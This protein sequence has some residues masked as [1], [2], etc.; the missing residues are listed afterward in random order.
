MSTTALISDAEMQV[1]A[2]VAETCAAAEVARLKAEIAKIEQEEAVRAEREKKEQELRL[3]ELE[4]EAAALREKLAAMNGIAAMGEPVDST[5]LSSDVANWLK[6]A[7]G[8]YGAKRKWCI[9]KAKEA[10]ESVSMPAP[11]PA[12]VA[13]TKPP[14]FSPP[15][16]GHGH[17]PGK[18]IWTDDMNHALVMVNVG[19]YDYNLGD[20]DP[21]RAAVIFMDAWQRNEL[22]E[23]NPSYLPAAAV[24]AAL[25]AFVAICPPP[26]PIHV[27]LVTCAAAPPRGRARPPRPALTARASSVQGVSVS[28]AVVYLANK[29]GVSQE[30]AEAVLAHLKP[31]EGHRPNTLLAQQFF[32]RFAKENGITVS[33]AIATMREWA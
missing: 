11:V 12:P 4:R 28:Y 24:E 23:D 2:C 29:V 10:Q 17:G 19:H 3:R 13:V 33:G 27:T 21:K 15:V 7:S 30:V 25:S 20:R 32:A 31:T 8:T 9:L 14:P 1:N 6:R 18:G 16:G 22:P 5:E 26:E